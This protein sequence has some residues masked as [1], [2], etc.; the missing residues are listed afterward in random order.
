MVIKEG[1]TSGREKMRRRRRRKEEGEEEKARRAVGRESDSRHFRV[2]HVPPLLMFGFF[3][4]LQRP[5]SSSYHLR[6]RLH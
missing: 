2:R 5:D 4:D 1:I 6:Q 3:Y